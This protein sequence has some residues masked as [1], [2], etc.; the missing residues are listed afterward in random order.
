[1]LPTLLD[2]AGVDPPKD[3]ELDGRS[4]LPQV[5]GEPGDPRQWVYCWYER[6]GVEKKAKEFA[7]DKRYKLYKDGRLFDYRADP[8]EAEPIAPGERT[9]E[10]RA[11]AERLEAAI[12]EHTR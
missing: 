10:Q 7:M 8:A 3:A 1:M 11:V 12:R 9:A 6:N 5:L 4:F 2:A